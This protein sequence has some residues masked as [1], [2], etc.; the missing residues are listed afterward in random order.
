M[1]QIRKRGTNVWQVG[2]YLGRD[3]EGKKSTHYETFYGNKTQAK[4]YAN[5]L[6]KVLKTR[7]GSLKN[8][9]M[10]VGELLDKWLVN[11]KDS[12]T[13]GTYQLY[14]RQVRKLK[15][16]VGDL[17]LY[18][19]NSLQIQERMLRLDKNLSPRTKKNHYVTLST[20]LNWGATCNLIPHDIMAGVKVPKVQRKKRDV[21]K[22]RELKIF[23]DTAKE[24]KHYLVLRILALTGTRISEVLGLKWANVFLDEKKIQIV[25]ALDIKNRD[26]KETKTVNSERD[27]ELDEVTINEL[28]EHKK[29][30]SK[31]NRAYDDDF[32]FQSDDG[33]PLRYQVVFK[34]K[35]RVLKKAGLHHIRLHDL[36]HGVGSILL[37]NGYPTVVVA[38]FLGQNHATTTSVYTHALR[39]GKSIASMIE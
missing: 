33:S 10:T 2:I 8:G 25:E 29:Y 38:S 3:E 30:M 35:Q 23:L 13:L 24:Y 28:A 39:K 6:E 18:T 16:L 7:V 34:A 9:I 15:P 12:I 27:I 19:L 20:A 14:Q 36:R 4:E 37:D 5:D 32:V 22:A 1:A 11:C 31:Q 21:L 26:E 17:Q